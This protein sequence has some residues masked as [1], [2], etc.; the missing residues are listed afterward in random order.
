MA[1]A[2]EF[3]IV[4]STEPTFL[5]NSGSA[6]VSNDALASVNAIVGGKL[7]IVFAKAAEI[8]QW[9]SIPQIAKSH[10]LIATGFDPNNH[11]KAGN[12]YST[13]DI[14]QTVSGT[15]DILPTLLAMMGCSADP[16]LYST[17]QNL[18]EPV[19]N[20]LVSTSGERIVM[21]HEGLRT[22]VMSNGSYEITEVVTGNRST[23]SLNTDLLSQAIKHLSR[24]SKP[25]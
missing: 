18:I 22:E 11:S 20:W 15:E 10:L 7:I 25:Q 19:R 13:A 5:T 21:I 23:D 6:T 9:L 24:F 16:G 2:F 8:E 1:E 14:Q 4:I 12:L 17:G 3:P